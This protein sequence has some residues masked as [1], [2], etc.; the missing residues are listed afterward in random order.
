MNSSGPDVEN[1]GERKRVLIVDDDRDFADSVVRILESRDYRV[2]SAYSAQE[3]CEVARR[4]DVQLALL[5]IRLGRENGIG[6]IDELKEIRPDILCVMVTAYAEIENAIEALQQGAYDYLRKPVSPPGLFATLDRC[7]ERLSL[8]RERA[9]LQAQLR[10]AQRLEAVGKF[11]TGVAHDLNNVFMAVTNFAHAARMAPSKE[12]KVVQALDGIIEVT[13]Q[14]TGLTRS[15]LTFSRAAPAEKSPVHLGRAVAK[16]IHLLSGMLPATIEIV[17]D[18]SSFPDLWVEG[19]ATQLQQV[20]LNLAV[21]AGDAMP[22]GG[23]LRIAVNHEPVDPADVLSAVTTKGKGAAVLMVEDTGVGMPE[24]VRTRIFEPFFTTKPRELGTGMG[25]AV[26]HGIVSDH[27]GHIDV[28]S[29]EGRGTRISATFPCCDP[30]PI[31]LANP[32][33]TLDPSTSTL[34]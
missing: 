24:E 27:H 9:A 19:D 1:E 28:D 33:D 25:M 11:A 29:Q 14:A 34:M 21:N 2:V 32:T 12:D 8:Q 31:T 23:Q 10:Q 17:A 15:L 18:A 3:A 13:E 5:D 4:F 6:L 26:V 7:F 30:P 20:V 16:S 22:D